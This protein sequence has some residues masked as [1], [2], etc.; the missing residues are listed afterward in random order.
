MRTK[1]FLALAAFVAAVLIFRWYAWTG[2]QHYPWP[3]PRVAARLFRLDGE[4]AEDAD[5]TETLVWF[6]AIT[7]VT[8]FAVYWAVSR[9][10]RS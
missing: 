8:V 7:E 2:Y 5:I 6:I 9:A 4:G 10:R 3:I 1:L